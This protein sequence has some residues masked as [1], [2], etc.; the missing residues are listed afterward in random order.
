[1]K[2]KF[3]SAFLLGAMTLAATSTMTSCKDY[4]DDITSLKEQIASLEDLVNTKEQTINSSIASLNEAIAKA[5]NDHA[6]KA[7]LEAAQKALQEAIDKKANSTDLVALDAKLSEAIAKAQAAADGAA[8]IA[9]E[10]TKEIEKIAGDLAKA[11]E[12]IG[13][14]SKGLEE[15][16]YNIGLLEAAI[17][18]QETAMKEADK[19]VIAQLQ[20]ELKAAKA[21]L[22]KK[23]DEE[24]AAVAKEV[25]AVKVS[26]DELQ[27][28]H[29]NLAANVTDLTSRVKNLEDKIGGFDVAIKMIAKA[30]RSLVFMPDLYVDGIEAIKYSYIDT[31][32]IKKTADL[33][34]TRNRA[35]ESPVT[36]SKY[37]DYK[38]ATTSVPVIYGPAWSV[39]YHM[40]PSKSDAEAT[41]VKGWAEREVEVIS[42]VEVGKLGLTSPVEKFK[43]ANGILTA[44]LQI[45][46]PN[47]INTTAKENIVALQV[48]SESA[49]SDTIITSDYAMLYGDPVVP[50]AIVYTKANN[51]ACTYSTTEF[52]IYDDPTTALREDPTVEIKWDDANGV[53]LSDY[54]KAHYYHMNVSGEHLT[55]A[56]GEEKLWGLHY[57][58]ETVEYESSANQTIDSKYCTLDKDNGTIIARAVDNN[59]NTTSAQNISSVGR[60]PLVRVKLMQGTSVLLDGYILVRIV[61]EVPGGAPARENKTIEDYATLD[62]K[63]T[64]NGCNAYGSGWTSWGEFDTWILQ[65]LGIEKTVF[66]SQYNIDGAINRIAST[67][68]TKYYDLNVYADNN[69]TASPVGAIQF[70][71]DALSAGVTNHSFELSLTEA[72][73]EKLTHDTTL[74]VTAVFYVRFTGT[75]N[76][77]YENVWVKF[78]VVLDRTSLKGEISKKL[79]NFWF[80]LDGNDNGWDAVVYNVDYPVNGGVTSTWNSEPQI[81]FQGDDVQASVGTAKKHFFV[82]IET[83]IK[84]HDGWEWTITPKRGQLDAVWNSLDCRYLTDNHTWP[85]ANGATDNAALGKILAECAINYEAGA[86]T[87]NALYATKDGVNYTKIATMNQSTGKITLVRSAANYNEPLDKIIN[88][89]GYEANHANISTEFHAWTGV[90]AENGC[91]VVVDLY[92]TPGDNNST[93][94][95]WESSWQRPINF[96]NAAPKNAV[97]AAT[98]GSYIRIYDLL[99]FYDW[100]GPVAGDMMGSNQWLWAYYNIYGIT[101][102]LDPAHV[103]TDFDGGVLGTTTL[104]SKTTKVHLYPATAIGAIDNVNLTK[105]FNVPLAGLNNSSSSSAVAAKA[106]QYGYIFYENNGANVTEFTVRIP[107]DIKY[108][109]GHFSTYVDVKIDRTLGN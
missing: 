17:K 107:L 24:I 31:K 21:E 32:D 18:A 101:I 19:A 100:R 44:G 8:K 94:A 63:T 35:G 4:D 80:A 26:I 7:A 56:W 15:A 75:A 92:N 16:A 105:T 66:E 82:P 45:A 34:V 40:N 103:T 25:D 65:N 30:L 62:W 68:E 74:P 13:T 10:N 49:N 57:E 96:N 69:G 9:G 48:K 78:D 90:V 6:T 36:L 79:D 27:T 47:L 98:N 91:K 87:N 14:L 43:N 61:K 109:W 50:A 46:K 11:N 54:I 108:E 33:S 88:A 58:F 86:F 85:I 12:T 2:K 71:V 73:I 72:E 67:S 70:R 52:H 83:K 102:D 77:Q 64:F 42:R 93:Y 37:Y 89:I 81:R 41:D 23:I 20:G 29:N 3:L 59:G 97:D 51:V 5:N 22:E 104:K 28:A 55:W 39:D 99:S 95:I 106:A 84:D 53:K 60:E 38:D 76:A 1:M